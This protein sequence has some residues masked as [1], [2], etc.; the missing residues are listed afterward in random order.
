M[1]G[2]PKLS[3]VVLARAAAVTGRCL[4][5]NPPELKEEYVSRANMMYL[6]FK[7]YSYTEQEIEAE[8]EEALRY[9]RGDR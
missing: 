1:F 7:W 4:Y 8:R 2:I 3:P 6:D 5:A 9:C